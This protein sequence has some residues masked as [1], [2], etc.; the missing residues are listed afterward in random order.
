M[1]LRMLQKNCPTQTAVFFQLPYSDNLV[2]EKENKINL[3]KRLVKKFTLCHW[4]LAIPR[5]S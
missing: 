5:H 3:I 2:I 1:R 4:Y